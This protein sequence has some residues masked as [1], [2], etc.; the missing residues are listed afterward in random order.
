MTL[1]NTSLKNKIHRRN[2]AINTVV[3]YYN[4]EKGKIYQPNH[5]QRQS[6]T[7]VAL[8][9]VKIK[10]DTKISKAAKVLKKA[11]SSLYK[12]KR[13]KIYFICLGN[14]KLPINK[15]IHKFYTPATVIK[16]F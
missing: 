7:G 11:K 15:Y 1:P 13:P 8:S 2:N 6:R 12:E 16:Y 3:D 9:Q 14:Q 5:C 10:K 4:V